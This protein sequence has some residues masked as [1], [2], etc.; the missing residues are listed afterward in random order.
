VLQP[1]SVL[2]DEADTT[3][4]VGMALMYGYEL[5]LPVL[6]GAAFS[7]TPVSGGAP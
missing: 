3:P 2:I 5:R 7:L 4:L 6:D 1:V